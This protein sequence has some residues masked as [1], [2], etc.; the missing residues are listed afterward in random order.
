MARHLYCQIA[1]AGI[2]I[3]FSEPGR[4]PKN[5]D[6]AHRCGLSCLVTENHLKDSP[7]SHRRR[8]HC[9]IENLKTGLAPH[10]RLTHSR[11]SRA[12]GFPLNLRKYGRQKKAGPPT[13]QVRA[14]GFAN[15]CPA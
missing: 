9:S 13:G 14:I 3:R 4:R 1:I 11:E 2:S 7:F 8:A 5:N 10:L 12:G 6:K 15:P